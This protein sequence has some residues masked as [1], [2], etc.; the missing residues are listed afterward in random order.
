MLS[1]SV[2]KILYLFKNKIIY[3]FYDI[4]FVATKNGRTNKIFPSSFGAVV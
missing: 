3:N 4:F 1:V 2:K